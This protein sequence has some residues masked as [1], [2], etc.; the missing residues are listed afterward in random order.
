ML[1]NEEEKLISPIWDHSSLMPTSNSHGVTPL[2]CIY[3][4]LTISMTID[5]IQP[6][7]DFQ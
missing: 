2:E 7:Y 4:A 6:Y 3:F 1:T 5:P